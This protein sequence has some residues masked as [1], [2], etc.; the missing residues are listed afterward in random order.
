MSRW[1][2][3]RDKVES[4]QKI[5]DNWSGFC[6]DA[7]NETAIKNAREVLVALRKMDFLPDSVNPSADGGV[8]FWFV[9]DELQCLIECYN[10]GGICAGVFEQHGN[11]WWYS[12]DNAET[13]GTI[14]SI[15]TATRARWREAI[16]RA[17]ERMCLTCWFYHVETWP[18]LGGWCDVMGSR[19]GRGTHKCLAY[20]DEVTM[21]Y[22]VA[23]TVIK[24][25]NVPAA[26][27]LLHAAGRMRWL[28]QSE[29][30]WAGK[31]DEVL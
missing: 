14:K 13:P 3:M 22:E 2:D 7:P 12:A 20:R 11:G 21:M 19:A 25:G 15:L 4:L 6:S 5:D 16:I 1:Q 29:Q 10:D 28:S 27:E 17:R 24:S 8:G 9:E 30:E 23:E 18:G 31:C 26:Q